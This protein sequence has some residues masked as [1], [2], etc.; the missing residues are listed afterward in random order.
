MDNHALVREAENLLAEMATAGRPWVWK[1]PALA[2]FLPFFTA[3]WG[4][5]VYVLAVRHSLDIARSWGGPP[6]MPPT[7]ALGATNLHRWQYITRLILDGVGHDPDVLF[8]PYHLLLSDAHE[9]ARRLCRFLDDKTVGA[10]G[11][12]STV[13]KMA[14]VVDPALANFNTRLGTEPDSRLTAA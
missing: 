12:D 14:G 4:D 1:D 13:D 2:F 10:R 11:T 6:A 7:V 9:S 5:A 3:L 8:L